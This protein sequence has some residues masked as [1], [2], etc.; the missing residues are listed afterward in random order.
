MVYLLHVFGEIWRCNTG[1]ALYIVLFTPQ[2][3]VLNFI[4]MVTQGLYSLSSKTFNIKS[5]VV[6]KSRD[7]ILWWSYRFEIWPASRQRWFRCT[8]TCQFS[9][10]VSKSRDW[11][12]WWS[13][14]FEIWPA[15]RQRWFRCTCTCQFSERLEKSQ[16][17]SR[18]FETSRDLIIRCLLPE[19]WSYVVCVKLITVA[20]HDLSCR[21]TEI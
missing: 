13:Y 21:P 1:I 9:L 16:P 14:R 6:S 18:D 7:W 5:L 4:R 12:L 3:C 17:E 10:V 2:V 20:L 15:S 11:I 8:C 19:L